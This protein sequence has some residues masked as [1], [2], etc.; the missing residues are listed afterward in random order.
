[1][2]NQFNLPDKRRAE[3]KQLITVVEWFEGTGSEAT[4]VREKLGVRTEDSSI[5][6]NPD[7]ETTTDIL[8]NTWTDVNKTEPQQDFDPFLVLGGSK[9]GA[10][11]F[12]ITM[13]NALPELQQFNVYIIS[14]FIGESGLWDTTKH[15]NCTIEVQSIGGDA[16]VNMPISVHYSN[17]ITRGTVDKL[18]DDFVFTA[19]TTTP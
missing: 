1:M 14:T 2:P 17:D 16:N 4:A 8:G 13:R 15:S 5:E 3:R 18:G 10:K 6:L 19:D 7:I 12:D 9:L 11:L